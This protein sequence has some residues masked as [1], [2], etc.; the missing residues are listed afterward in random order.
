[1]SRVILQEKI[2]LELPWFCKKRNSDSEMY[3][4]QG[5]KRITVELNPVFYIASLESLL[6]ENVA[7]HS[8]SDSAASLLSTL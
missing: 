7:F 3:P 1:M 8:W 2:Y 6:P 4:V 5:M